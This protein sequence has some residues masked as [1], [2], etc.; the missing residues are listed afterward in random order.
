MSQAGITKA[1]M[2]D[3]LELQGWKRLSR[4]PGA[5]TVWED[6]RGEFAGWT[7]EEAYAL[8]KRENERGSSRW[9]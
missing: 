6:P 3:Y 1:D 4:K 5:R 8:C 9:T 2:A 7:T